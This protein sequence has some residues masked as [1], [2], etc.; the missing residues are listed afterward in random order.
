MPSAPEPTARISFEHVSKK[1][2]KQYTYDSLR[3]LIPALVTRALASAPRHENNQNE[4]WALKNV[5]FAVENGEALGIMGPNGAGKSTILKL[6]TRILK[7]TSGR[8]AISG[9]VGALIELTAGFHEDLSGREN[10]FLQGAL[11]GMKRAEIARKFD[12]VVEFSGIPDFIDAPVKNYSSGMHARLGFAIAAHMNPDVLL[13]DEIL[14]VGD[15]AFQKRAMDRIEQLARRGMP[16][17]I[18]SHQLERLA[19]LC[20][21]A[22]LLDRGE[23]VKAGSPGDCIETYVQQQAFTEDGASGCALRLESLVRTSPEVVITGHRAVVVLRG[24]VPEDY[25]TGSEEVILRI[26]SLE[27]GQILFAIGKERFATLLPAGGPFAIEAE[28]QMNVQPGVYLIE[29]QVRSQ[30]RTQ[31]R[32]R[33][34]A[35]ACARQGRRAVLRVDSDERA[36]RAGRVR[37]ASATAGSSPWPAREGRA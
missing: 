5:S 6:L 13:I 32:R 10:V 37:P 7:P 31:V 33:R 22:I 29:S 16:V 23:I 3:D 14:S 4:F 30:T 9:R 28:L 27:S 2:Q 17:I 25:Q 36:R 21:K 19:A 12:E 34:P 35:D 26:R 18:V 1:F 20:T 15:L 8:C 24:V 11:M